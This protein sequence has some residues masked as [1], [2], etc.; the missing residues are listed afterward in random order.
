MFPLF[1]IFY[2]RFFWLSLM[3]MAVFVMTSPPAQTQEPYKS[4]ILRPASGSTT[5]N[6]V[7]GLNTVPNARM[8][9]V[10]TIRL[11]A[12]TSDPYLN[13]FLGFQILKPLYV[14]F[15]Q[16]S[17]ISSLNDA[18]DRVYPALDFK[19]KLL[20]ETAQRPVIVLG[21]D[22]VI[23]H[24]RTSSE[25][26]AFSKR[27]SNFDFTGG[28]AWGRL[29][30][31]GHI[32]NPFSAISSHFD[33]D[34]DFNN[35]NPQG[36]DGWFTGDKIGFFGGVE[37]FTPIKNLSLKADFGGNDY[38][39]E[40]TTNQN[41]NQPSSFSF[42][43]N[44][45]PWKQL[46]LSAGFVGFEKVMA[47]LSV[48]DQLQ[49]LPMSIV[50]KL[51][52]PR[53]KK[54]DDDKNLA[55][56]D[57]SKL[58]LRRY[59]STTQ[60]IGQRIK[61]LTD[62]DEKIDISLQ[63]MGLKGPKIRLIRHDIDNAVSKTSGSPEEIWRDVQFLNPARD[64]IS[65]KNFFKELKNT[66]VDYRFILD[67][68]ISFSEDDATILYRSSALLDN[69]IM[70]PYGLVLGNESR[71]NLVDNL[72]DIQNIRPVPNDRGR[73]DE[74]SFAAN[75]LS[76]NRSYVSWLR[77]L[78][79]STHLNVTAGYLEEQFAGYGAEILYRPFGKTFAIGAEG[80][81][82]IR[83]DADAPFALGI[84][85]DDT[86]TGHA[87]LFYELPN[88]T[89]TLYG[90]AGRYLAKDWGSTFGV[91]NQ[92]K[93]GSKLDGF[94]TVTNRRD[95]DIFSGK[96]HLYGGMKLTVPIGKGK[97]LPQGSEVRLTTAPFARDA[98]Q[99]LDHPN[100]LY[101]ITEPIS[102]R[103]IHQSWPDLLR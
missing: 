43:V 22:S 5:L 103:Q 21:A 61:I 51:Q 94:I 24:K 42:G 16:T 3:V 89:T 101:Q 87:S 56:Q 65:F 52:P 14:N 7:R 63:H 80:W 96:N 40:S 1:S 69:K 25:Y 4:N 98:G 91:Q 68:Q 83:R 79:Q 71:I 34:R 82:A 23:G 62:A 2:Y 67:N 75:R 77:S 57:L 33:Q 76:I 15:R 49:N 28:I 66:Q 20:K 30:G 26:I 50:S 53:R 64:K 72:S 81:K 59:Q 9:D 17:E 85:D 36:L 99:I 78:S 6:G 97:Y 38:D 13:S 70:L 95:R 47:R 73:G 8:D 55:E 88:Q 12:G 19:L 44:Y 60:Q 41:F 93:N 90:K 29:A 74:A 10:G 35:E 84:T 100:K 11:G 48:Q 58:N 31:T 32:K 27:K 54:D 18:A 102:Y 86:I 92:F 37:Y 39:I 46:N 45:A